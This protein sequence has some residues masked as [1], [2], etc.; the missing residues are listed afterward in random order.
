MSDHLLASP[1]YHHEEVVEHSNPDILKAY[2]LKQKDD[3]SNPYKDEPFGGF[4]YTSARGGV[5]VRPYIE[6]PTKQI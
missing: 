2:I 1:E 3:Y 4:D 5:K 6:P